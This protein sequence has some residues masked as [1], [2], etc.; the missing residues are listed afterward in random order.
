MKALLLLFV[1]NFYLM[2]DSLAPKKEYVIVSEGR[3]HFFCM[4]PPKTD[5]KN[6]RYIQTQTPKGT[7]YELKENGELK[8]LWEVNGW[9]SFNTYL[10]YKGR[11]LVSVDSFHSGYKPTNSD[12]ALRFFDKSKLIKKYTTADLVKDGEEVGVST[13]HYSWVSFFI[14]PKIDID[15]KFTINTYSKE[16]LTFDVRTGKLLS[17]EK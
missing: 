10:S 2:G 4:I 6:G 7:L 3:K 9:Y 17:R 13:S 11:Y 1:A 15:N 16:K 5:K 8:P 12:I 14:E